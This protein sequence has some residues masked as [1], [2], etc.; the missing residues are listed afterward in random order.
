MLVNHGLIIVSVRTASWQDWQL[1]YSLS[2]ADRA[3]KD[4]YE[5]KLQQID[6]ADPYE[7][8]MGEWS[9]DL[10]DSPTIAIHCLAIYICIYTALRCNYN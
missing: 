9:E 2:I 1:L 4:R 5:A 6:S 7:I 10:D 8:S 3:L